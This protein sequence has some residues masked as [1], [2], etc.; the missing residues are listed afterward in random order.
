MAIAA[1]A[2]RDWPEA[3]PELTHTLLGAIRERG[4]ADAGACAARSASH[5]RMR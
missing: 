5:A 2:R 4:S 3:W 1:I